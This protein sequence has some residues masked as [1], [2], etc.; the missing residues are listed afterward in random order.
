[1][2]VAERLPAGAT[3]LTMIPD[4]GRSYMSKFY[5]DNWMLEHGFVERAGAVPTVDEL[6]HA[7]HGGAMPELVTISAHAKVGEGIDTMQRYG[8]SQVPVVRNGECESLADVIGS[9]QD[10]ALLERVFA[11]ADARAR[12]RRRRDAA[13]AQG[14]RG[15]GIAR[16]GVLDADERHERRRRRTR[17]QAGRRAHALGSSRV[18]R[19]P[20][21]MLRVVGAGLPRTGTKSLKAALE[22]LLGGT[23]YHMTELFNRHAEDLPVWQEAIRG[24]DVDW[25]SFLPEFVA[26]VDWPASA[27]WRELAEANPG[28]VIVLSTRE[29]AAQWWESCDATVFPAMRKAEYPEYAEWL[30]MAHALLEREI[31]DGWNDRA[32][33]EAFYER[34]NAEV[35]RDAPAGRLVE[36]RASDGWEPLCAALGVPIPDEPFPNTNAR[37]EWSA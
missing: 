15:V 11:N 32:A 31:G 28:A 20:R 34:H 18:P 2:Q 27:F 13:A 35:R 5:D 3:V 36:W 8:I 37:A 33:E 14:G 29:S 9:L 1:M 24:G 23:C 7:K 22:I 25:A 21:L 4:S 17:G 10:R 30:A 19:A 12:G 26:A 6:L 16:R